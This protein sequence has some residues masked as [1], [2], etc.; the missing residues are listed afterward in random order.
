MIPSY[1]NLLYIYCFFLP[2]NDLIS[3]PFVGNKLQL[4]EF[5]F[6]FIFLIFLRDLVWEQL[7]KWKPFIFFFSLYFLVNV[8]SSFQAE[9]INAQLEV[10]GRVYLG[11]VAMVFGT[12]IYNEGNKA[13]LGLFKWWTWGV[14][15]SALIGLLGVLLASL[16]GSP[17][18]AVQWYF[19]YPYFGDTIRLIGGSG[20]PSMFVAV[21]ILPFLFYCQLRNRCYLHVIILMILALAL[22]LTYS[23]DLLPIVCGLFLIAISHWKLHWGI[24]CL[25]FVF[26]LLLYN[27]FTNILFTPNPEGTLE[28]KLSEKR[29]NANIPIGHL[30]DFELQ[31]STYLLLKKVAYQVGNKNFWLGVGP[32]Q[33]NIELDRLKQEEK[34]PKHI[35]SYDPHS[36]WFGAYAETGISGFIV[37]LALALFFFLQLYTGWLKSSDEF[38]QITSISFLVLILISTNT[39]IMNFRFLW[40]IIGIGLGQSLRS[41]HNTRIVGEIQTFYQ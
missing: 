33:F 3:L 32:G 17:N 19:D 15:L 38:L 2:F 6:P 35:P 7:K 41:N 21:T 27:V 29:Y 11:L 22:L 30:G 4:T 5:I 36:T 39:D 40:V 31:G 25:T 34:F 12:F 28:N 16:S 23:K 26:F 37:T 10:L 18:G 20:T 13:A 1:S 14:L 24:S 8:L 9:S